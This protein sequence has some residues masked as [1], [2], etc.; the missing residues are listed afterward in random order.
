MSRVGFLITGGNGFIGSHTVVE[1]FNYLHSC[2]Q[3]LNNEAF[4]I[5]IID[6]YCNSGPDVLERI[7]LTIDNPLSRECI[8]L[9]KESIDIYH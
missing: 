9:Y 1:L 3:D 7:H 4:R 5:V 8:H 2:P 6:N